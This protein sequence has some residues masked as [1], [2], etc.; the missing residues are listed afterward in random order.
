[1][2]LKRGRDGSLGVAVQGSS[3]GG[4]IQLTYAPVFEIDA[5]GAAV[6]VGPMLNGVVEAASQR[7]LSTLMNDLNNGGQFAYAT[8]RR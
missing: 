2:P 4:A 7:A 1:M 5:R 8:G 3:A 6:G